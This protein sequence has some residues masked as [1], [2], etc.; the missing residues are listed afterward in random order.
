MISGKCSGR[1]VREFGKDHWPKRFAA[2][3]RV[4]EWVTSLEGHV[5][6][7]VHVIYFDV[8]DEFGVELVLKVVGS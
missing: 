8:D 7:V 5:L 6:E 2:V 4:G 3:P 1:G